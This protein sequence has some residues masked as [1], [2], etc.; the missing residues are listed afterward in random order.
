[1]AIKTSL[2]NQCKSKPI[3]ALDKN[4]KAKAN[5][6]NPKTTFSVLSQPPDL[7][8]LPKKL[9]TKAK[10]INGNAN[11]NPKPNIAIDKIVAPP[12]EFNEVPKTN[13]NAG[14]IHE[15]ETIIKVNAIKKI[16]INPPLFEA[17]S[18]LLLKP[19]GIVISNAPKKDI[20]KTVKI[21]KKKKLT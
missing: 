13:P 19:L 1:M 6:T 21:T 14:P 16:P 20:A 7:G 2:C 3:S 18:V 11:P 12:S 15:N 8:I 10:N 5:S 4:L 17:L 9:G